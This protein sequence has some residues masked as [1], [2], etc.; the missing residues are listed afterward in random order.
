M[1]VRLAALRHLFQ[2][3]LSWQIVRSIFASILLIEVLI[4]F[5]SIYH[6]QQQL[7][8]QLKEISS[9]EATGALRMLPSGTTDQQV[10]A[11]LR[12]SIQNPKI[13][14]GA[15]YRTDRSLDRSLIGTFGEP[16][17]LP[18]S[19]V[20]RHAQ[21]DLLQQ[22]RYDAAWWMSSLPA[23]YVLIIRHDTTTVQQEIVAFIG[24]IMGLVLIISMFV[25]IAT[26]MVLEPLLI[27]PIMI[28]RQDLL[29]AGAA[30]KADQPPLQFASKRS[31]DELGDV[32]EAFGLM[33]G[34][35]TEAIAERKQAESR[36]AR[37]AEVGELSA[38]IVHEV[39]NPLTTIL[40][41]L[42]SFAKLDLPDVARLRLGL[43]QE[44]GDRLK[45][46]LNEILNYSKCQILN[47]VELDLNELVTEILN[48][49]QDMPMTQNRQIKF[50]PAESPAMILGDRDKLKQVF[51]N[52]V[53][54]ACE[55]VTEN[56]MII[57]SVHRLPCQAMIQ[58]F[59]SGEPINSEAL[60]KMTQ[61]FFTTKASG[62]GLGLAIVKRIIEA[63]GGTL[64]IE[65]GELLH[66]AETLTGT[67]VG[68]TIPLA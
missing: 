52:L 45:R 67:R 65:S 54:N 30:I 9:V 61:P 8:A 2:A 66:G 48:S 31:P 60:Q 46:L 15:L 58:V 53:D 27:T 17:Q 40:M 33:Y 21:A 5:P 56:E 37:L 16:P 34:Q 36:L 39:R 10:L 57:W 64:A 43:A 14:G 32:I 22:N 1:A 68:I 20:Q 6:R 49:I 23:H 55:A 63:H 3:R 59:N 29:K 12:Q 44:E 4:L 24:R 41:G 42:D 7:L 25:T 18:L 38:M 62:N 51:I 11:R 19:A 35:V 47:A 13:V 26:L 28:L 50:M